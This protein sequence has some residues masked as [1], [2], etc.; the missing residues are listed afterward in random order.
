MEELKNNE[1]KTGTAAEKTETCAAELAQAKERL[2]YLTADFDNYRRRVEK[3][4][5]QWS[6]FAQEAILKDLIA[7]VDDFDRSA[8]E[9]AGNVGF[10]LI[11]KACKKMLQKYGV[12]EITQV[13]TFDPHLHEAIMSVPAEGKE[14]GTIVQVFQKGYMFK[15]AVLR[16]AQVSVVQ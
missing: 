3:E 12:E 5:L 2:L 14:P 16:P 11:Y 8:S 6:Q 1:E 13:T 4:K 15:G 9:L 7:L 10:E